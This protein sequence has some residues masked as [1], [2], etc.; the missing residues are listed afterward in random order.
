MAHSPAETVSTDRRILSIAEDHMRRFGMER[1]TVSAVAKDAGMTHA[2]IY[3]YFPS[4][5]ALADAVTALWLR[6]LEALATGIADAPDPAADKLERLLLAV[7]RAHR[8]QML[9]EPNIYALLG[10]AY[11]ENR[12]VA[13]T[14]RSR[15]LRLIERILEEGISSEAFT[16][17]ERDRAVR[18]IFDLLYRFL[19]PAPVALDR[20][21]PDRVME[22]RQA[23]ALRTLLLTL[24]MGG[25]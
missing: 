23:M 24:R 11:A 19:N 17:T 18:L 12:P 16:L 21:V 4:K 6:E 13:R 14:H 20:A 25:L 9:A 1:T 8:Q 22:T 15:L 10:E 3:R 2:N 7:M 5:T